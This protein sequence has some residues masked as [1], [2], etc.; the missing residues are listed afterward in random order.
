MF[1]VRLSR[2]FEGN[3]SVQCFGEKDGE[4]NSLDSL[5]AFAALERNFQT[6]R[7]AKGRS[8]RASCFMLL[9]HSFTSLCAVEW[10]RW[11]FRKLT[12]S[13]SPRAIRNR[14][15]TIAFLSSF[16]KLK[17]IWRIKHSRLSKR[18][19]L[20]LFTY[21]GRIQDC[22]KENK[23]KDSVLG[24]RGKCWKCGWIKIG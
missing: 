16:V 3:L 20:R 12:R 7:C 15:V 10:I 22:A 1:N 5:F 8:F 19:H 24:R 14:F 6:L 11:K 9:L 17:S 13:L 4:G 21:R 23:K 2:D 18:I